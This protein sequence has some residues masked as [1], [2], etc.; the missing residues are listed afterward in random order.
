MLAPT[1]AAFAFFWWIIFVVAWAVFLFITITIARAKGR[2][3]LLWGIL[4]C[5]F[6]LITIII[7]LLLPPRPLE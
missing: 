4:A 2:S 1:V 6:P 5:F 3:A 7:V